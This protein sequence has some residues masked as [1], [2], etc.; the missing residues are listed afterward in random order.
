M[1]VFT[2][3][4]YWWDRFL[5][6]WLITDMAKAMSG[7][8]FTIENIGNLVMPKYCSHLPYVASKFLFGRNIPSFI[9]VLHGLA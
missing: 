2:A 7:R 1:I 5:T 6:K 3:S 4:V 8:V 9:R